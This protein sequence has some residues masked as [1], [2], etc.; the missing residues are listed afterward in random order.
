MVCYQP[1]TDIVEFRG[2]PEYCKIYSFHTPA[3]K[4]RNLGWVGVLLPYGKYEM[5][6]ET[7]SGTAR[8]FVSIEEREQYLFVDCDSL[9]LS[10][11]N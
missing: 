8:G 4:A 1:N 7:S 9:T 3:G 2:S 11:Y 10:V 6:A 5:T